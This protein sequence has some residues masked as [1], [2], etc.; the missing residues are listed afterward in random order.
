MKRIIIS[1]LIAAGLVAVTLWYFADAPTPKEEIIRAQQ[2]AQFKQLLPLA[3]EGN[4]SAQVLVAGFYKNGIG[5][6]KNLNEAWALYRKAAERGHPDAQYELGHMYETGQGV[7]ANPYRAAEWYKLAAGFGRHREAQ[8]A[9]GQLYLTGRGVPHGYAEAVPWFLKAANQGHPAA[10]YLMGAVYLEGWS[11][12]ADVIEA[13]KW[14][15]LA[16]NVAD[17]AMAYDRTYDPARALKRLRPKMNKFQVKRAEEAAARFRPKM[18][19]PAMGASGR[20]I[21]P[22]R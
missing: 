10:L 7:R 14:F 20:P 16:L 19:K 18:E 13:Y 3:I 12:P 15:T 4:P 5:V 21:V 2:A 6:E 11:A 9:L 17:Q 1:T 8:Y 22:A